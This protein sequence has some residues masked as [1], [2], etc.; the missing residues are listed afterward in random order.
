MDTNY[1]VYNFENKCKEL[2]LTTEQLI[3]IHQSIQD[4]PYSFYVRRLN[5]HR[6]KEAIKNGKYI[7]K[8]NNTFIP[9]SNL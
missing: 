4:E 2:N 8:N 1:W 6:R 5:R 7:S 3:R 9:L